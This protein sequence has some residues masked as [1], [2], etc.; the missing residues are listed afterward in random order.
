MRPK[1]PE[2]VRPTLHYGRDIIETAGT[3][4]QEL[5]LCLLQCGQYSLADKVIIKAEEVDLQSVDILDLHF[6]YSNLGKFFYGIRDTNPHA[7]ARAIDACEKQIAIAPKAI[8]ACN[9][10]FNGTLTSHYG[11]KQLAIIREKLK[12]YAGAV[13][14]CQQALDQGWDGDWQKRISKL[15][16]KIAKQS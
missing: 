15:Q 13:R 3:F 10:A 14:L 16:E 11:Y 8:I 4:L 1:I 5:V 9:L 2:R 6:L 7:L 12:D